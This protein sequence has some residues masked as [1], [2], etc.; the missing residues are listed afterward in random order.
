MQQFLKSTS[1]AAR[2][3]IVAPELFGQFD[4]AADDAVA[5]P[6]L[7]FGREG[8]PPLTRDA[9]S[10]GGRRHCDACAWHASIE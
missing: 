7:G 8:L 6:D 5:A 3:Q 1:G 10:R 4:I 2:A 9:E